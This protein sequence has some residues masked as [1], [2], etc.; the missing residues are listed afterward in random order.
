MQKDRNALINVNFLE[1]GYVYSRVTSI[2][3]C[4]VALIFMLNLIGLKLHLFEL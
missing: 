1:V 3:D 2:P 4:K